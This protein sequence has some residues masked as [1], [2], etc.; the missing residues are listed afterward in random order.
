ML[1]ASQAEFL[2]GATAFIRE[3]IAN[4]EPIL[5]VVDASKIAALEAALDGS[6]H[7][8]STGGHVTF[9]DMATVGQNPARIIPAWHD[10][11]EGHR[12]QAPSSRM[13]GI[14]EPIWAGRSATELVECRQHEALLNL[15]FA[16]ADGFTLLC[17]YDTSSLDPT[18]IEQAH[19]THPEIHRHQA[20][21]PSPRYDGVHP[22]DLLTEPLDDPPATVTT[23]EFGR[24]LAP[25]RHFAADFVAAMGFRGRAADV[26]LVVGELATNSVR[27]GG[28]SGTVHLW[29][30]GAALVCEVRDRGRIV[31]PMIGRR[32]PVRGQMGGRGLWLVNQLCDLVQIRSGAAG[33]TVRVQLRLA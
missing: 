15:A 21:S 3:G 11:V 23:L 2:E 30:R 33:S 19:G 4:G 8:G 6:G 32:K 13:R 17:P 14:G 1:Y 5:V 12:L 20:C 22:D 28:G 18:V 25:V 31:D 16:D 10:F 29:T 9:A 26:A 7:A 27:H 24:R